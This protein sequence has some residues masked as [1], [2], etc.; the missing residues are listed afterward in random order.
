MRILSLALVDFRNYA[1]LTFVPGPGA[2]VLLGANGAGKTN[3]LEALHLVVTGMS[4]RASRDREMIRHGCH[5]FSVR[6]RVARVALDGDAVDYQVTMTGGR[7]AVRRAGKELT[8]RSRSGAAGGAVVFSPDDLDLIKG[9]PGGRRTYLDQV[10]HKADAGY[11]TLTRRYD[12]ALAHRNRVLSEDYRH[13]TTAAGEDQLKPW[14]EQ[15]ILAGATIMQWRMRGLER[16]APLAAV[17]YRAVSGGQEQLALAYQPSGTDDPADGPPKAESRSGL[18]EYL[19]GRF[20]S[21]AAA[22]R[23]R[24][25]TL[26]GPHRD[27]VAVSLGD[28]PAKTYGSQGQ[29]RSAALA[30]RLAEVELLQ[31]VLGERPLLLLDD[32]F[33]ELDERRRQALLQL[34]RLDDHDHQTFVTATDLMGLPL[35][36]LGPVAAYLVSGGAVSRA[37]GA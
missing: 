5:A 13:A 20:A 14:T 24:R 27:D 9:A 18:E 12:A 21:V 33:S 35:D 11:R 8:G 7:K 31:D 1:D 34:L 17:A 37:N 3:V 36:E 26:A 15:L 29:Q 10:L 4:H 22:E 6:A 19:R 16:L 25:V 23:A 28:T 32:V 2:N 30:L